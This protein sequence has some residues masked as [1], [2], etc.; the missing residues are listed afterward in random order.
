MGN[1]ALNASKTLLLS[2]FLWV[3]FLKV[4]A[5]ISAPNRLTDDLA[6]KTMIETRPPS[7]RRPYFRILLISLGLEILCA[8]AN[9]GCELGRLLGWVYKLKKIALL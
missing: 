6:V 9:I 1:R 7:V 2:R 5:E 8:L 4:L 3:D